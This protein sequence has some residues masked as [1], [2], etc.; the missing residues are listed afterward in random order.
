MV[1]S[2]V[3]ALIVTSITSRLFL[4]SIP[5]SAICSF[6]S[7]KILTSSAELKSAI[8]IRLLY[9]LAISGTRTS[10][11]S[12]ILLMQARR[13]PAAYSSSEIWLVFFESRVPPTSFT[14]HFP[15]APFPPQGASIAT[16]VFLATSRRLSP[17]AAKTVTSSLF[18]NLKVTLCIYYSS[19]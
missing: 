8:F 2:N 6:N 14:L 16:F 17:K 12:M 7:S 4:S 19:R 18:S 3:G 5:T 13:Q 9:A 15:Q 11:S 1:S 10:T